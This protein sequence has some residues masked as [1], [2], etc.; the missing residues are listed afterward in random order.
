MARHLDHLERQHV[1]DAATELQVCRRAALAALSSAG[2]SP[3]GRVTGAEVVAVGDVAGWTIRHAP[4][5]RHLLS[6]RYAA[7]GAA[8]GRSLPTNR[9]L[10][11]DGVQMVS[12]FDYETADRA[13]RTLLEADES[14]VYLYAFAPLQMK[15]VDRTQ[16]LIQGP[17]VDGRQ[18]LLRLT[19][20]AALHTAWAYWNAVLRTARPCHAEDD[21]VVA[22]GDALTPRQWLALDLLRQGLSDERVAAALG[23]SV[24]TVRSEVRA[25]STAL[26]ADSRFAAGFAFARAQ[27]PR[28][29]ASPPEDS[30]ATGG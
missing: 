14:G 23:V 30:H 13:A 27:R 16:V 25:A 1:L 28:A 17:A 18:S 22:H 4:S 5:W 10:G 9:E 6:T 29:A 2:S 3:H 21:E 12:V 26:H 19:A 7:T 8:L 24:R 11:R 20:P 15:I